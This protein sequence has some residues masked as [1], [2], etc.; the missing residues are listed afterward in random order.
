MTGTPDGDPPMPQLAVKLTLPF[1][2]QRRPGSFSAD[3]LAP[4]PPTASR[5]FVLASRLRALHLDSAGVP[6]RLGTHEKTQKPP[7]APLDT[8]PSLQG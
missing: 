1:T 4:D 3:N 8:D 2:T 7:D 5:S 6:S